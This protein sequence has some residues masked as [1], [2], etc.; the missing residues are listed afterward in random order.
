MFKPIKPSKLIDKD[1]IENLSDNIKLL[2][3]IKRIVK[4]VGKFYPKGD[5]PTFDEILSKLHVDY[6]PLAGAYIRYNL[7]VPNPNYSRQ[8]EKYEKELKKYKLYLKE[9]RKKEEEQEI[10]KAEALLKK[11]GRLK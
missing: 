9:E 11:H 5:G 8:M 4:C 7:R 1:I 2:S 6:Y 10:K 3:R